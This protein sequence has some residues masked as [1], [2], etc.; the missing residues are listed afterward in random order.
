MITRHYRDRMLHNSLSI[1]SVGVILSL[2]AALPIPHSLA[3]EV[4]PVLEKV[5]VTARKKTETLQD[6]PM[7]VSALSAEM[8]ENKGF[9][10]LSAIGE[11][12]PGLCFEAFDPTRPLVYVRGIGT[13]AYDAGS[14]PSVGVFVDGAYNGRFGSLNM[15]L[16]DVE[17][18]EVLKGPQGTLYGRNTIGGAISVITRDPAGQLEVDLSGEIGGSSESGDDIWSTSAAVSL[19]LAPGVTSLPGSDKPYTA[20][21]N[22]SDIDLEREALSASLKLDWQFEGLDLTSITTFRSMNLEGLNELDGSELDYSINPIDEDTDTLSQEFRLADDFRDV[23][24]LLV[25]Y[26]TGYKPRG[27]QFIALTPLVAEQ[28]FDPEEV[29]QVEFGIKATLFDQRLKVNAS[30][31]DMDYEDLQLLRVSPGPIPGVSFVTISDAGE[32]TIQGF[33]LEGSALLSSALTL[34]FGF[35]YLDAEF[36]DYVFDPEAGIDFSGNTLPRAPE[37]SYTLSLRHEATLGRGDLRSTVSYNWQDDAYFEA[38]NNQIDPGSSQDSHGLLNA[39]IA[40]AM[41][42]WT[43]TLWGTNL[44]DEEYRRSVLND[45]GYSQRRCSLPRQPLVSS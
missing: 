5:L 18:I 13:R 9:V 19:P 8:L 2:G 27:F 23:S 1:H 39:S 33:E 7:S 28:V 35:S 42:S 43:F 41:D 29:T 26:S 17:R 20:L 45:T 6:V 3:Q 15:N 40:Y 22:R 30:V 36:D 12:T 32:S 34:D 31:F 38:D 10:D 44:L 16:L 37:Y 25:T 14:D 11:M 21:G 24:W 4:S